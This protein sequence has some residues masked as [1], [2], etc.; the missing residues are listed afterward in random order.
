MMSAMWKLSVAIGVACVACKGGT[1]AGEDPSDD[2]DL[3]GTGSETDTDTDT[4]TYT[5]PTE[6][7]DCSTLPDR[8]TVWNRMDNIPMSEDFTIDTDGY[9]WGVN[10]ETTALVKT[11]YGGTPELVVPSVSSWGRGTRFLSTGDLVIA[12]PDGGQL[13]RVDVTTGSVTPVVGDLQEPNGIAVD[14]DDWV[15]LTEMNGR[16]N[17]INPYGGERSVIFDN[18]VST[19]GITFSPDYSTLYWNSES[20]EVIQAEID[21]EGAIVGTPSVLALIDDM[22]FF[23]LLDGMTADVCGNLYVV[24]MSGYIVRVTPQGQQEVVV[25]LTGVPGGVF[26]SAANFGSGFGGFERE[27]LYV[28]NLNGGVFEIEMGIPGKWEPHL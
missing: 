4:D 28:M 2:T 24:R 21:A 25:D 17:R 11:L 10:A 14:E 7:Y 20:G 9:L 5:P 3:P 16:V 18:P 13:I 26:I 27:N 12:E 22:A 1:P 15:Y 6:T 19:D 23:D 8:P